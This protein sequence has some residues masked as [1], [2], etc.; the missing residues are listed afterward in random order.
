[1]YGRRG[2]DELSRWVWI[3]WLAMAISNIIIKSTFLS[4]AQL[5]A[6]VIFF[7]RV[8]SRNIGA[9]DRENRQFLKIVKDIKSFFQFQLQKI[10]QIGTHRYIKCP[11]CKATLRVP[12]KTGTHTVNCPKCK[13]KFEKK[14]LF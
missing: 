6:A 9:R 3:C 5:L 2:L 14:I 8:L 7:Y 10:R 13:N 1:M 12:R 4:A 11:N